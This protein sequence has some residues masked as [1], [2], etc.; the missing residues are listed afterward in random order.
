M[1][2]SLNLLCRG[3]DEENCYSFINASEIHRGSTFDE[4]LVS[5]TPVDNLCMAM[6][7]IMPGCLNDAFRASLA[8]HNEMR[9]RFLC[10]ASPLGV[11]Q[12]FVFYF[13]NSCLRQN[14]HLEEAIQL[15]CQVNMCS[16]MH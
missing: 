13:V 2:F 14:A 15:L 16:S 12:D 11:A 10:A 5:I 6:E 4:K 7:K 3:A 8:G 1:F 9:T